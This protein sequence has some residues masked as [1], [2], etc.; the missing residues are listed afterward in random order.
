MKRSAKWLLLPILTAAVT[1]GV[2][3]IRAARIG[4]ATFPA[5]ASFTATPRIVR[6][7]ETVTLKWETRGVKSVAMQWSASL[8]PRNSQR[9]TGLPPSGTM[10]DRPEETTIYVLECEDSVGQVCMSAST[11]VLVK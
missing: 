5:I 1:L 6:P 10:T 3:R 9:R 4:P 2:M 11:T 8:H 7:G